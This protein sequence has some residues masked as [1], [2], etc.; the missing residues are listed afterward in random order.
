MK[1][2]RAAGGPV[3]AARCAGS[4]RGGGPAPTPTSPAI[5]AIPSA[6]AQARPSATSL[7]MDGYSRFAG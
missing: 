5:D 3:S 6:S 4:H 1:R 7:R 2:T